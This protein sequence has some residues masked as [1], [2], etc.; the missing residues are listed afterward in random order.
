MNFV[1]AKETV[2][3]LRALVLS[4]DLGVITRAHMMAPSRSP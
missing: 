1:Y 3:Q 4:E 2:K